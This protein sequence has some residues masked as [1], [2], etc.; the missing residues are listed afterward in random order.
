M[1]SVNPY[2]ANRSGLLRNHNASVQDQRVN[3]ID[4]LSRRSSLL[5]ASRPER[6]YT[7]TEHDNKPQIL[8]ISEQTRRL[9]LRKITTFASASESPTSWRR[10]LGSAHR[11][12]IPHRA[13][14][15]LISGRCGNKPAPTLRRMQL[16]S[17]LMPFPPQGRPSQ[18]CYIAIRA[19]SGP[20]WPRNSHVLNPIRRELYE[21]YWANLLGKCP[22][23]YIYHHLGI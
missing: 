3:L 22:A 20:S 7:L 12:R 10:R 6:G 9:H 21:R 8:N 1:D 2:T 4:P 18:S 13:V 14:L 5:S 23:L 11:V 15:S 16:A 17:V 19:I